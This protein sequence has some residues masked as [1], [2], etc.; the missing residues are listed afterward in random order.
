MPERGLPPRF[1][2][3]VQDNETEDAMN[4]DFYVQRD[5]EASAR[6]SVR[7][8]FRNYLEGLTNQ[9][10]HISTRDYRPKFVDSLLAMARFLGETETTALVGEVRETLW[11]RVGN[12][13]LDNAFLRPFLEY[14]AR[15][16]FM[17]VSKVLD[18]LRAYP[19]DV[20]EDT[21]V[22]DGLQISQ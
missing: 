11:K 4:I 14:S 5:G 20:Q 22:Q 17:G 16:Q 7:M 21:V 8:H 12:A 1:L 19:L 9:K 15:V 13:G 18:A 10:S 6:E 3:T 2:Y